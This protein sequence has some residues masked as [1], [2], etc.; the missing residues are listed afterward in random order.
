MQVANE[1]IRQLLKNNGIYQWQVAQKL[2]MKDTNFSRLMREE[3]EQSKKQKIKNI[4][5]DILKERK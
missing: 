4:I 5:S 3:L 2:G 1:D